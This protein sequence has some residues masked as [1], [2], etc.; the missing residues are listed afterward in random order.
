MPSGPGY[1]AVNVPQFGGLNDFGYTD[2]PLA[3]ITPSPK[4]T[5]SITLTYSQ[6]SVSSTR[7]GTC[8]G[9]SYPQACL[10]YRSYIRNNPGN[11]PITCLAV[12]NPQNA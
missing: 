9:N 12:D 5:Q 2:L 1:V 10:N 3:A 11:N 8:S 4:P 6:T 7:T